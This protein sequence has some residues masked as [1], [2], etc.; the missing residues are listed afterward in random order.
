MSVARLFSVFRQEL[1]FQVTRPLFWIFLALLALMAWGLSSGGVR[2]QA[3]DSDVGGEK[4]FITSEFALS[5][6]LSILGGLFYTFFV[7]VAA[8]MAIV[9][10]DELKVGEVLHSTPLRPA[11]YVW[12]KYLAVFVTFFGLAF[13][14]AMLHAFFNHVVPNAD[15]ADFRGPLALS[16]YLRPM[17]FFLVP[18][19]IF[20]S[21]V[22]FALGERFRKPILTFSIPVLAIIVWVTFLLSW[23]PSWLDPR[24]NQAL[25]WIEPS[26]FRWLNETWLKVDRGVLLYNT[27]SVGF[28]AAYY[29]SRLAFCAVGLGLVA[30]S[31]SHFRSASR[32]ARPSAKHLAEGQR[33]L[34]AESAGGVEPGA[35]NGSGG[36]R[37]TRPLHSL[38]MSVSRRGFLR[39]LWSV[40]RFELKSIKGQAGLYL[41]IPLI[42]LQSVENGYLRVGAFDTPLLLTSGTYAV[43]TMN[44]LTLMVCL[45]LLFYIVESLLREEATGAAPIVHAT[46]VE[47]SAFLFGKALAN[48]FVGVLILIVTFLAGAVILLVQKKVAVELRP[49][50]IVWGLLLIPT[51]LVW[52]GF[53]IATYSIVRNRYTTYAIG[54]GV[55][56]LTAYLQFRGK[57]NWVT[58]WDLW[59]ITTWTDFGTI[60]PNGTAL[61]LNRLLYLALTGLLVSIAVRFFP[62]RDLDRARVLDRIR[63]RSVFLSLLRMS[64]FWVPVLAIGIVLGGKVHASFQAKAA[65]NRERDYWRKNILTWLDA[66]QPY[67]AGVDLDLTL[68]PDESSFAVSGTFDLFHDEAAPLDKFALSIGDHFEDIVWTMNGDETEPE[69]RARLIVFPLDPPLAPGDTIQVGFAYHGRYPDGVTK[70]GGGMGEFILP[71]GVVLTC[72]SNSFLPTIG[73]DESRGVDPEKPTEARVYPKDFYVGKTAPAFGSQRPFPVRTKITGPDRFDYHAPGV[74]L[75]D[76]SADGA[77]T[78]VWETDAPVNFFNVVAGAWDVWEGEGTE[79]YH[80]PSHTY[81]LEEM[82]KAL[83]A[84]RRYYSEWFYPYPWAELRVNEFPGIASYAQGFPSNITFSESI[85]FLT[86][87]TD[88]V[89]TAFLVTAHES[90]HQWWG[91]LVLPG[92][93]PGGS[94]VS[95]GMAHFSTMLLFDRVYGE[96]DRIE[97]C[98]RIEERYGDS[99]QVDSERPLVEIDGSRPGDTTV[100]YD[101]GGW[102]F[103]MLHDLMGP[104]S[105]LVALQDFVRTYRESDDHPVLQ[106]Y[107]AS[108][109][110]HAPDTEAF[111]SFVD[112]WFFDV[113]VPEFAFRDVTKEERDGRWIVRGTLENKGTGV[114]AVDVAALR[115]ERPGAGEPGARLGS[116]TR[117][118]HTVGAAAGSD[119]EMASLTKFVE[120]GADPAAEPA[121]ERDGEQSEESEPYLEARTRI[122]LGAGESASFEVE[123]EFEPEKVLA[124]PDARVLQILRESAVATL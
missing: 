122:A 57:I 100:T 85:G 110:R 71:C 76:T 3:G 94:I 106:D 119:P 42:I 67:L 84:A 68:D 99:R 35:A 13:V 4:S 24:I 80:L 55:F 88:E 9:R 95:E 19:L 15:A 115:G 66:P 34:S 77:R 1:R 111:D 105:S 52:S 2:I 83:D 7:A 31:T 5:F 96:K 120:E 61:L 118:A 107:V 60:Q 36:M 28:D 54:V 101:K 23:S 56:L 74:K 81:N 86:R 116:A 65:E 26:G 21:G 33:M 70:N 17:V 50:L 47:N 123:C 102:V 124:D 41:F 29:L 44:S 109:R 59:G 58:N 38:A 64:P 98:K 117:T 90:A 39:N 112:Q 69:D 30:L 113:V 12:G 6:I 104:D 53:V 22:F 78:V 16:H 49:F 79:L 20:A 18:Q 87:S 11:E 46:P 10:D 82:G 45:L 62:R 14:Q 63:P 73:F 121:A 32:G 108:M 25:M 72:F 114:V 48:S 93:G 89:K 27:G 8:G 37:R 51:F 75:S 40:T 92:K 43:G 103:W 97:F 91:N